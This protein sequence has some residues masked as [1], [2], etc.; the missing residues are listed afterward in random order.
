MAN[1]FAGWFGAAVDYFAAWFGGTGGA[2]PVVT[3][4]DF[5]SLVLCSVA[6]QPTIEIVTATQGT[7]EIAVALQGT[8]FCAGE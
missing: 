3:M 4:P 6:V 2:P 5:A 8:V 1:Y 7:V